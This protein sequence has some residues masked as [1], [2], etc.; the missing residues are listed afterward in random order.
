MPV[1]YAVAAAAIARF[2]IELEM[3]DTPEAGDEEHDCHCGSSCCSGSYTDTETD[4]GDVDHAI[5]AMF[6]RSFTGRTRDHGDMHDY[7]CSCRQCDCNRV[8]PWLAVQEDCTVGVEFITRITRIDEW[9]L[10]DELGDAVDAVYREIQKP[11]QY[12]PWGNHVHVDMTVCGRAEAVA[13]WSTAL[14]ASEHWDWEALSAGGRHGN[15]GYNDKPEKRYVGSW[16]RARRDTVEYRLWNTPTEGRFIGFHVAASVAIARWAWLQAERVD[17]TF[18][19][20]V[21]AEV[22]GLD[23][24]QVLADITECWPDVTD[25]DSHISMLAAG[26]HL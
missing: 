1:T 11:Y 26:L 20:D 2:G 18:Y 13:T 19:Q 17:R 16:V 7:H 9:A 22:D 25:R 15:R 21:V 24:R 14:F 10:V 4:F 8:E 6:R 5:D 23:H 3:C 12:A